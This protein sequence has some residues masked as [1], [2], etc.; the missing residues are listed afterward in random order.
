MTAFKFKNHISSFA[1][2]RTQHDSCSNSIFG[3]KSHAVNYD[4]IQA[5]YEILYENNHRYNPIK[6]SLSYT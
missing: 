3:F 1:W 6:P 2:V 4:P 5:E